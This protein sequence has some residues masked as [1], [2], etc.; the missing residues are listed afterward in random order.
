[1][2]ESVECLGDASQSLEGN[3]IVILVKMCQIMLKSVCT[4]DFR[5][6]FKSTEA[7]SVN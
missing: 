6:C 7:N 1:M 4:G 3:Q 5:T 2:E